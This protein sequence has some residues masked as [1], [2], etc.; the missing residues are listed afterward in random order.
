MVRFSDITQIESR[1]RKKESTSKAGSAKKDGFWFSETQPLLNGEEGISADNTV[2][3]DSAAPSEA[4]KAEYEKLMNLAVETKERVKNDKGISPSPLLSALHHILDN[5]LIDPLY[6]YS[7]SVLGQYEEFL[8]HTIDVTFVSLKVGTGMGYDTR[9]LLRLGLTAFLENIGMYKIPDSILNKEGKLEPEE[10]AAIKR[11]PEI[12]ADILG[13]MGK[14]YQWLAELTIQSHERSDGSGYPNGLKG[15][16]ISEISS[17]IGVIDTYVAMIKKRPYR[18]KLIQTDA[19]KSILKTS[20]GLFP[21]RI[22]KAFFNQI[23]LF[24]VNSYVRLNNKSIGRVISTE[25]D[26]PMRPTIALIYDSQRKKLGRPKVIRLS[27]NPLLHIAD[28]V[29]EQELP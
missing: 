11:H 28:S 27:D 9:D 6:E 5:N 26:Q 4:Q 13:R 7:M 10:I 19:V 14:K 29:K 16:E 24:P 8:E 23:S 22:V 18:E 12:G 3:S 17:I 25:K 2:G 21:S 20:K 15:D 1:K